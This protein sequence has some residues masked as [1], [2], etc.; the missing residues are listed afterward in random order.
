[1]RLWSPAQRIAVLSTGLTE[2]HGLAEALMCLFDGSR[3]YSVP[4]KA[5]VAS[6]G[7]KFPYPGFTSTPLKQ[8]HV[9]EPPESACEL[10]ER[11]AQEALGDR[12]AQ[13]P[14][15]DLVILVD[16][17]ELVHVGQ[18][19]LVVDVLR[20][21]ARHHLARLAAPMRA[22][23][24]AVLREKVSFHLLVPMIEAWF[25]A[26]PAALR[27]A[28]VPASRPVVF[29]AQQ[30]PEQFCTDD[31]AYLSAGSGDCPKWTALPPDRQK[32]LR[33]K[34]LGASPREQHPK[35]YLQWLCIDG[36]QRGCTTYKESA[37]GARALGGLHWPTVFSR[38]PT[39]LAFLAALLDDVSDAVNVPLAGL[40]GRS[41]APETSLACGGQSGILRNI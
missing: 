33:P 27:T 30:D 23:T 21:A 13:H 11:A 6:Y 4:T 25:F 35:G 24:A 34:W 19:P 16:D 38:Q 39:Q 17:L 36:S 5:E 1:M 37:S 15:A 18:I 32:K 28:G 40:A 14:P 9:A 29:T 41:L 3:F 20:A 2:W 31:P 12:K 8:F 7:E 22:R 10:I 26:D